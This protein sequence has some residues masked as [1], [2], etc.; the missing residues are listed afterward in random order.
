MSVVSNGYSVREVNL[1]LSFR[2][3]GKNVPLARDVSKKFIAIH[4][5]HEFGEHKFI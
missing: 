3:Q 1:V 2:E 5:L 4:L